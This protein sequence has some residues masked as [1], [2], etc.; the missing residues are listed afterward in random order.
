MPKTRPNRAERW[1]AQGYRYDN[2]NLWR[3]L[4]TLLDDHGRTPTLMLPEHLA[5][6]VYRDSENT[7]LPWLR[8]QL[9]APVIHI[10]GHDRGDGNGWQVRSDWRERLVVMQDATPDTL[11]RWWRTLEAT[12]RSTR[13]KRTEQAHVEIFDQSVPTTHRRAVALTRYTCTLCTG[14]SW[15]DDPRGIQHYWQGTGAV[16][17]CPLIRLRRK[18]RERERVA[19]SAP[20]PTRVPLGALHWLADYFLQVGDY[21]WDWADTVRREHNWRSTADSAGL[22]L[23]GEAAVH[24]A[25]LCTL[26]I[27]PTRQDV[28][29][30]IRYFHRAGAWPVGAG[31]ERANELVVWLYREAARRLEDLLAQVA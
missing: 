11:L 30:Y 24:I 16:G 1:L 12:L 7:Y 29:A 18:I 5:P 15:D 21:A 2:V 28:G 9:L 8:D 19:A 10:R 4:C 13:L 6:L 25:E 14:T 23:I 17:E 3:E 26:W 20:Q 22:S 31:V 27:E